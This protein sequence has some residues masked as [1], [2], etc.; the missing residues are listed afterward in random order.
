M[1]RAVG[2]QPTLWEAILPAQLITMS[3]ELEKVDGLLDDPSLAP[4]QA[5][6]HERLGRPSIPIEVY[7]LLMFLKYRYRLGFEPLVK[8]VADSISGSASAASPLAD[9]SHIRPR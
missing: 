2:D 4:Y 3:K 9:G 7:L 8:E 1:L 5:F 6:F